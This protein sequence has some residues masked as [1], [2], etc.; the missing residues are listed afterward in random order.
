MDILSLTDLNGEVG[1]LFHVQT[2]ELESPI[3]LEPKGSD[4]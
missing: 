1:K 2:C 3:S 4:F